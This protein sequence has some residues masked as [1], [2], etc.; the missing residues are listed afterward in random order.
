[1]F[2]ILNNLNLKL[3]TLVLLSEHF[4]KWAEPFYKYGPMGLFFLAVIESSFFP[5]PP[6]FVLIALAFE[7]PEK[8]F[9]YATICTVGSV[10]G[11]VFGWLIGKFGGEPIVRRIIGKEKL[12]RGKNL[13]GK[14]DVLAVAIAG[15]TPIP[16]K[17]FT[18]SSGIIN[19][20]L[21]K[22]LIVSFFARGGRFFLVGAF[23]FFW[24][25]KAKDWIEHNF[26][27]F[28]MGIGVG[29]IIVFLV[30]YYFVKRKKR[31]A[32]T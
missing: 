7:S 20:N 8:S 4:E 12:D 16:Y 31:K 10:I 19:M 26:A 24:G 11:A 2:A 5:V 27:V 30:Y 9:Y 14:Y 13:L 1:M 3:A 21:P 28:T 32:K 22:M 25:Q 18:I 23:F 17:V 6:D 15:F 29:I